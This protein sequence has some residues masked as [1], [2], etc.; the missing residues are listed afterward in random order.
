MKKLITVTLVVA[1]LVTLGACAQQPAAPDPAPAPA[2]EAAPAP[3]TLE[4]PWGDVSNQVYYHI[5]A[6]AGTEY[7]KMH[8]DGFAAAGEFFGVQTMYVGPSD[9]NIDQVISDFE[10]AIAAKP[11]G[12]IAIGWDDSMIPVIN[13]SVDSGI[14]VVT[15]D[16]DI[17]GSKRVAFVGT[18]N[19]DAG[20][21]MGEFIAQEIGGQ[22][23]VAILGI[24]TLSNIRAR[25]DGIE[26]VWAE[27]YPGIESLGLVDSQAE[28]N[29]AA[30]NIAAVIQAHPDIAAICTIDSEAGAGAIM[31]IR[32]AGKIGEI[33]AA[34][35]DRGSEILA[36]VEEGIMSAT[37]VQQT[38]LMPFYSLNILFNLNN[39]TIVQT[40][41]DAAAG[42]PGI[43]SYIDTGVTICTKDSVE[44]FKN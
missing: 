39:I 15:C 23:K 35:F 43:P 26:A 37:I 24:P 11:N 42:M 4:G 8:E 16:A 44:Y 3:S 38:H 18:S 33:K 5:V 40:K 20:K 10:T 36:A 28:S 30:A 34:A 1:L 12:I 9:H 6:N 25:A 14:P 19:F 41:D 32:E 17:D 13:K 21:V 29:A 2:E 31:A 22:G 27:N 7:F